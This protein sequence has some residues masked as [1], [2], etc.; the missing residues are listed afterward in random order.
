MKL[1]LEA[2][3]RFERYLFNSLALFGPCISIFS[4]GY[5]S[6]YSSTRGVYM[7]SYLIWIFEGTYALRPKKPGFLPNLWAATKYFCKKTRVLSPC[8]YESR[9]KL[10]IA[11]FPSNHSNSP[12]TSS[13]SKSLKRLQEKELIVLTSFGDFPNTTII[14]S[15]IAPVTSITSTIA[16]FL[17][18]KQP[19]SI[20]RSRVF[21]Q[22]HLKSVTTNFCPAFLK[23]LQGKDLTVAAT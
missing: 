11:Q 7:S 4:E 14:K 10:A 3:W 20:L 23:P 15:S 18:P 9:T 19:F 16:Q 5:L 21:L 12:I 1:V 6:S 17:I 8:P 13:Y 22:N 2:K